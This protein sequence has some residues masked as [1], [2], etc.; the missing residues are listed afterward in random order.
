MMANTSIHMRNNENPAP[1]LDLDL[2]LLVVF[3][4]ILAERNISVA[5]ERLEL[6]QPTVSNA[7]NRLRR[8]TGDQL[9]VR[10]SHGME[11]TLHAERIAQ[12]LREVLATL[13]STLKAPQRFDPPTAER[14]F[15]LFLTDLGEAYFLPRLLTRLRRQAPGVKLVTLPIP[16]RNPQSALENGEVDI[17]IGNLP[18]LR[19]G[20]YQQRLFR[21]HYI[22]IARA[23]HPLFEGRM[24]VHKF[25]QASHAVVLPYGTGHGVVEQTMN[26]LG[27]ADRIMLRVQNFLVL[28]TVVASTDLVAIVPHSVAA[29]LSAEHPLKLVAPPI[30]LPEFDI[31]QCWHK[32]FHTDAGNQWL[33]SQI[34]ELF[35]RR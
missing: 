12:P 5:A 21:E 4:A 13:R 11:P 18:R 34:A 6:A 26:R 7:L 31:K 22:C 10:T 28:P 17:A 20:F 32:R 35:M 8:I 14:T 30:P 2:K 29:E 25:G 23:D 15:T 9:F 3:D 24:T 27:L 16:D 19:T 1:D 33:R